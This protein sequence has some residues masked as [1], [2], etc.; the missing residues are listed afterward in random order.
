[1]IYLDNASTYFPRP[2]CVYDAMDYVNRT[3]SVNAGRGD[4]KVAKEA[5]QIINRVRDKLLELFDCKGSTEAVFTPSVTHA[6]NQ[7]LHGLDINENTVIYISPY[8]HNAVART[9]SFIEKCTHCKVYFLPLDKNTLELD[10]AHTEYLF[11][12]QEPDIVISTVIS[13]VTG[14]RLPVEAI[15]ATARKYNAICIA[16]AAQAAGLID[17]SLEK[18]NADII[19]FAGH[20]TLC[21]PLGIGGFVIR[22]GVKLSEHLVGGTGSDSLNLEMPEDAPYRYE[23]GSPNIV[24]IAGLE[25]AL[26]W[27]LENPHLAKVNELTCMLIDELEQIEKC[28]VL[29]VS[30]KKNCHG[31]VS[32]VV[33]GYESVDVGH[34]LD[35]EFDIAVRTGYHC[36]AYIHDF[37]DDKAYGGSVRVG[38]GPF[39]TE[40]DIRNLIEAIK[41][42]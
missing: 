27:I 40:D 15:F 34:I 3:I 39:N 31:I 1:M 10:V 21:G 7:V 18:M 16:D 9:V 28:R 33:D 2:P 6:I 36:A 25:K 26:E 30:D 38:I 37:L 29:G 32:F 12:E 22:K 35:E 42:L 19:C 5:Y 24:A 8:E 23:A 17:I 4:Y 14:Y 41:T 20:K 11:K 13:N